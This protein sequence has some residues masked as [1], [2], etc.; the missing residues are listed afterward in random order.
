MNYELL[1]KKLKLATDFSPPPKKLSYEDVVAVAITRSDLEDDVHGINAS[2]D[3]IR[4][5][6]GGGCPRGQ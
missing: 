5:T 6:R 3:L 1:T 4:R 2:L